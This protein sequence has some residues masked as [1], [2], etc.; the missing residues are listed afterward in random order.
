MYIK[1]ARPS[2]A[3]VSS[4]ADVTGPYGEDGTPRLRFRPEVS[5]L[6]VQVIKFKYHM[7]PRDQLVM[8]PDPDEKL[9]RLREE[10]RKQLD[11][12]EVCVLEVDTPEPCVILFDTVAFL[13]NDQG[14]TME[15][16]QPQQLYLARKIVMREVDKGQGHLEG[17]EH[18]EFNE[19]HD[20][21]CH[22]CGL[23]REDLVHEEDSFP[24]N[25]CKDH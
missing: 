17:V 4:E 3:P 18:H 5:W 8:W 9:L 2:P 19:A 22:T 14:Q 15:K 6:N 13:C 12:D 23:E 1:I 16:I 7:I 25:A 21:K 11:Y 24:G 10:G 20:G